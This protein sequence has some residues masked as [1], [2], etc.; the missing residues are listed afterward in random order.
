VQSWKSGENQ[1]LDERQ[2]DYGARFYDPVIGRWNTI[3]PL[4]AI[5][6]RTSPYAYVLNN[7]IRLVDPDGMTEEQASATSLHDMLEGKNN[8]GGIAFGGNNNQDAGKTKTIETSPSDTPN[9]GTATGVPNSTDDGGGKDGK[10]AANR[11]E[12]K[13][14]GILHKIADGVLASGVSVDAANAFVKA[15]AGAKIFYRNINGVLH[16]V[17]TSKVNGV[18]EELS[19][20]TVVAGVIVDGVLFVTGQQSSTKTGMNLTVTAIAFATSGPAGL[21]IVTGYVLLDKFGVFD[22]RAGF[23]PVNHENALPD[24]LKYVNPQTTNK[25]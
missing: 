7:P 23:Y 14:E 17:A 24:A 3:D 18:L 20:T 6:R 10:P 22:P 16:W 2:Y 15:N 5:S 19:H 21:L 1:K 8:G 9:G 25:N 13:E 11:G 12:A 4:A